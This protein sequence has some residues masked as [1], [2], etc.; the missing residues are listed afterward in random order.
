MNRKRI[1]GALAT[2][3]L[4]PIT[5]LLGMQSSANKNDI[6][7]A[8]ALQAMQACIK[9]NQLVTK[10]NPQLQ[11]VRQESL[12]KQAINYIENI[13]AE[14]KRNVERPDLAQLNQLAFAENRSRE[15]FT[16]LLDEILAHFGLLYET[17][18]RFFGKTYKISS[19][20]NQDQPIIGAMYNQFLEI[21]H[22]ATKQ[23]DWSKTVRIT[24]PSLQKNGNTIS[25]SLTL[26]EIVNAL[27]QV[28]L[29]DQGMST[30][31]KAGLIIGGTAAVGAALYGNQQLYNSYYNNP[32]IVPPA[33]QVY[34]DD[35]M[36]DLK[37]DL[38][39]GQK[40]NDQIV[41]AIKISG[42]L[43]Q[44]QENVD[45][46]LN[47]NAQPVIEI[48]QVTEIPN[49]IKTKETNYDQIISPAKEIKEININ[50]T[51]AVNDT[52]ADNSLSTLEKQIDL[53]PTNLD[54]PEKTNN[55]IL[56]EITAPGVDSTI[57]E[58]Q[59]K[60]P[61][62]Q[63]FSQE[64][65]GKQESNTTNNNSEEVIEI[66]VQIPGTNDIGTIS[67]TA[68]EVIDRTTRQIAKA[69]ALTDEN[70]NN[71]TAQKELI[72]A[73]GIFEK[74]QN[75]DLSALT[76]E[77]YKN[78]GLGFAGAAVGAKAIKS[79][80]QPSIITQK[81]II[82]YN[83]LESYNLDSKNWYEIL[84]VSK[85]ATEKEIA[86]AY[87]KRSLELHP[88]KFK[89][90]IEKIKAKQAFQKLNSAKTRLSN[91]DSVQN[92]IDRKYEINEEISKNLKKHFK[93]P[94]DADAAIKEIQEK[95]ILEKI[96]LG[97]KLWKDETLQNNIWEEAKIS[98]KLNKEFN[99]KNNENFEK[100]K[101]K[102]TGKKDSTVEDLQYALKD[103][104]ATAK[105]IG[106]TFYTAPILIKGANAV[107]KLEFKD[108]LYNS[109][110]E[111]IQ[112]D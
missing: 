39:N 77:D 7:V 94:I 54:L 33:L 92:L 107:D 44:A 8:D 38:Q 29:P 14:S 111:T 4:L 78:I 109:H 87:R 21:L 57:K 108:D 86:A 50:D 36:N 11:Q 69:Q 72:Q 98:E 110:I 71:Q 28:P 103:K 34:Q 90:P 26:Q 10:N 67:T 43:N 5:G 46:N 22:N 15:L 93:N 101:T 112:A 68:E 83:S 65:A 24:L 18:S 25:R 85:D 9:F 37:K 53:V 59:A 61:L 60:A 74:L 16:Y 40:L 32:G 31:T 1:Y 75:G 102:I 49:T 27:E 47:N 84:G 13:R 30:L 3:L 106:H 100:L 70:P 58:T 82:P 51:T 105:S 81:A 52:D 23:S 45:N 97:Y 20:E 62:E 17:K 66:R 64:I 63:P 19:I 99:K 91:K 48:S 96:K 56:E 104:W 6:I 88:D 79:K 76:V 95:T 41:P 73:Q 35:N 12:F 55:S 42:Q 80:I 2:L 89:D